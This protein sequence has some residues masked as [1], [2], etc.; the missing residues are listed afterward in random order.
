MWRFF[1]VRCSGAEAGAQDAARGGRPVRE[2]VRAVLLDVPQELLA[3]DAFRAAH[4][5]RG[6]EGLSGVPQLAPQV[7]HHAP[8][9]VPVESSAG[10]TVFQLVIVLL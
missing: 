2:R 9:Y 8:L 6:H 7:A 4:S 3:F 1:C 5:A 10:C